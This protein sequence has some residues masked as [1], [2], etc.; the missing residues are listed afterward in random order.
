MGDDDG[1]ALPQ[2]GPHGAL[3]APLGGGVEAGG[4]LV[5][6][7]QAGGAQEGAGQGQQL[8]LPRGE[9]QAPEARRPAL[10]PRPPPAGAQH[11]VQSRREGG[12]PGAQLQGSQGLQDALLGDGGVE[13]G[14][15][16]PHAALE[17]LHLLG[18]QGHPPA[19][20]RQAG[21]AQVDAPQAHRPRGGVVEAEEEAGHRGLT[22]P[23]APD[24]AQHLS[25][26]EAE[27]DVLQG[28][29]VR[30][31]GEVHPLEGHRE[32]AVR[33]G[34][35]RAVH[36]DAA[37][38]Q[39]VLDAPDPRRRPLQILRLAAELL[40]RLAQ[41]L[42]VA[43]DQEDG[44]QGDLPRPEEGGPQDEGDGGGQGED[45][46]GAGARGRAQDE[47]LALLAQQVPHPLVEAAHGVGHGPVGA[48]VL[49]PREALLQEAEQGGAGLPGGG[50]VG[51]RDRL[52]RAQ[53][54]EGD[55]G[56]GAEGEAEARVDPGQQDQDAPQQEDVPH[57]LHGEAGEEVAEQ[58]DV[59]V[60][61]LDQ[62]ARGVGVVELG[63]EAQA[64]QGQV[65]PQGV[66]GLLPDVGGQVRLRHRHHL[67]Q[68]RDAQEEGG[69]GGQA[70]GGGA[71][72]GGVD[73]GG[74]DLRA[75]Q[76]QGDPH[77]QQPGQGGGAGPLGAEVD[78][79]EAPVAR[80]GDVQG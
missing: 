29:A 34:V 15:V 37:R 58:V 16:V 1:G 7:H 46:G 8:R 35:A 9:P 64:V 2:Q 59:P 79:Q 40:D 45:D 4:G 80:E 41:Q 55:H 27:G 74:H 6:D 39:E 57:H 60:H 53:H 12:Q 47:S 19:H 28:R 3:D 63:V 66:G 5:Q 71:P 73:E 77:H 76:L 70:L 50:A 78:G 72:H 22:A 23:G 67:P 14:Q 32:G 38:L 54:G 10:A 36:H 42:G 18:H 61:P 56:E 20:V 65:C 68:G 43:D 11:G 21:P 26:L 75:Q 24:Q 69:P 25:R 44:A 30:V 52:H 62:L 17:Q 51:H 33:D 13:H 31:V 48:Q 49:H